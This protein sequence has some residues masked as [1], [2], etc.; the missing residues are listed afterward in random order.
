MTYNVFC[1]M[2]NLAQQP[3]PKTETCIFSCKAYY[4]TTRLVASFPRQH[5]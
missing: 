3:K 1:G 5:G 4:Y 2:L